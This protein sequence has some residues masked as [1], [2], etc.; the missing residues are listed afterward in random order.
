M[1][2][3]ICSIMLKARVKKKINLEDFYQRIVGHYS[4]EYNPDITNRVIVHLDQA[5]V[6][7]FTSGTI[8]VYLKTPE[9]KEETIREVDHMISLIHPTLKP[10]RSFETLRRTP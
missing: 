4:A 2:Y 6:L 9:K 1:D 7:F 5:S 8:Q 3:K 10:P